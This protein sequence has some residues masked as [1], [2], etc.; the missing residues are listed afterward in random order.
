MQSIPAGAIAS[1]L[2]LR[3]KWHKPLASV[4]KFDGL[5]GFIALPTSLPIA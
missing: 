2:L 4:V 5:S 3:S 1:S